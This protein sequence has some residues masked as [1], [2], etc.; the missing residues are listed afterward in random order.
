MCAAASPTL[1]EL[2]GYEGLLPAGKKHQSSSGSTHEDR[3]APLIKQLQVRRRILLQESQS[4]LEQFSTV[5]FSLVSF[6]V[7]KSRSLMIRYEV[8]CLA[9][10]C[11]AAL[12]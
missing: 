10:S 7:H 11:S 4:P 5:L 1:N 2:W 3:V 9:I 12:L 8:I 6:W